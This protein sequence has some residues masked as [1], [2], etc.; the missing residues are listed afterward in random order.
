MEGEGN[1]RSRWRVRGE[2]GEI[3]S[4]EKNCTKAKEKPP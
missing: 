2:E 3:S 4:S 1:D